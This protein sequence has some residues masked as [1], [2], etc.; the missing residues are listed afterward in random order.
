MHLP[1]AQVTVHRIGGLDG[2]VLG[3]EEV[4]RGKQAERFFFE[5]AFATT[6]KNQEEQRA[7]PCFGI[8]Q[9]FSHGVLSDWL[10]VGV[11]SK[12]VGTGDGVNPKVNAI[13]D[14]RVG[15]DLGGV[16]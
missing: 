4:G 7:G 3:G 9:Y 2:V 16:A 5:E 1:V 15:N 6:G 12:G 10:K 8:Q 13:G 11:N 14:H